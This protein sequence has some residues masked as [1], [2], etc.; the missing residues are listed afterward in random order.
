MAHFD[1][2]V[3]GLGVM[4]S[5]ALQALAGRVQRVI[6]IER[7]TPGHDHGSSHGITRLIRLGY[8]EHSSYVPL[9]RRAYELWRG[10]EQASGQKLM[11]VT[12]I[13]EI[14]PPDGVLVQG[15]LA[16]AR[17]HSLPHEVFDAQD[18]MRRYPAFRVPADFV[19]V[20]QPDGAFLEAAPSIRAW[21]ALAKDAGAEIRTGE[22]I[23]AIAPHAGGVRIVSDRGS[24]EAGTVIVAAGP[25][26]KK[27]LPDLPA[28][29]RV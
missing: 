7:F 11:H 14:G 23:R 5:A 24:V 6:G 20:V 16:S 17:A 18:F 9:L 8:F 22:T 4:G 26:T 27:L 15:T 10:L 21:L 12:G 19:G 29:L 28:A 13:A 25:W 3:I 1:V 2:A